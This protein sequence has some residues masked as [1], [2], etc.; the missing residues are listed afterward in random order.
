MDMG[1][2][3]SFLDVGQ[4][5]AMLRLSVATIRRWVLT[6]FIPYRKIGRA[7]RFSEAELREWAQ[8]MS[9][10]PPE[11]QAGKGAAAGKIEGGGR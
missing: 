1:E 6:G 7:V 5:A 8:G 4:V 2:L 9:V 3:E 11:R 10:A